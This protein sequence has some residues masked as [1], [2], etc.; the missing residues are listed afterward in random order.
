MVLFQNTLPVK[1]IKSCSAASEIMD[2]V[3][4]TVPGLQNEGWFDPW[5]LMAALK[6]KLASWDTKFVTGEVVGFDGDTIR[7]VADGE[8]K[9]K[10]NLHLIKVRTDK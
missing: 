7:A 6:M 9:Q 4:V 3:F 8:V 10:K 1:M 2:V 5:L